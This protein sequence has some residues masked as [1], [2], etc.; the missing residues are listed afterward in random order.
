[1]INKNIGF[2]NK[3]VGTTK[4]L[5]DKNYISFIQPKVMQK[6][7]YSSFKQIYNSKPSHGS[8]KTFHW[9]SHKW[10]DA[11]NLVSE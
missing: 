1:M 7:D 11:D 8:S 10:G 4:I 6:I 9:V 2:L 3:L 5:A